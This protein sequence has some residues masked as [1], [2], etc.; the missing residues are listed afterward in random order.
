MSKSQSAKSELVRDARSYIKR[1]MLQIT[2]YDY[3][4]RITDAIADEVAEDIRETSDF[5]TTGEWSYGD[6]GLAIGRVLCKRLGIE[7]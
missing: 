4:E 7:V 6:M 1:H 3:A 5:A 2:D